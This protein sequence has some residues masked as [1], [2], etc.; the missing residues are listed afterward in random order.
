MSTRIR[1]FDFETTG[2]K[3]FNKTGKAEVRYA[4]LGSKLDYSKSVEQL[5]KTMRFKEFFTLRD[6]LTAVCK[7]ENKTIMY[8]V[9][10]SKFDGE[11]VVKF[12]REHHDL[13]DTL[14]EADFK[15]DKEN[16]NFVKSP[17]QLTDYEIG[18]KAFAITMD[19][20][21]KI[22]EIRLR[23]I[24]NK[25]IIFRCFLNL[26]GPTMGVKACMKALKWDEELKTI[27]TQE[28]YDLY[29]CSHDEFME[30][31]KDI[32]FLNKRREY[33]RYDIVAPTAYILNDVLNN[34]YSPFTVHQKVPLTIASHSFSLFKKLYNANNSWAYASHFIGYKYCEEKGCESRWCKHKK[35]R[36]EP[37]LS[38]ELYNDIMLF[39]Y[40][41]GYAFYNEKYLDKVINRVASM[42]IHSSYPYEYCNK[43]LPYGKPRF[44]K[45]KQIYTNKDKKLYMFFIEI[46][47]LRYKD[48][49]NILPPFFPASRVSAN[50]RYIINYT[51][52]A[53]CPKIKIGVWKE[54]LDDF[55]R[56]YE[57]E[58]TYSYT[59]EFDCDNSIGEVMKPIVA[60]KWDKTITSEQRGGAKLIANSFTGKFGENFEKTSVV[61]MIDRN[62][63]VQEWAKN[64]IFPKKYPP[65][66]SRI[67]YLARHHL[68]MQE[69]KVLKLG[70][71]ILYG[72]TDSIKF[73]NIKITPE[74]KKELNIGDELGQWGLEWENYDFK[75]LAPK[76][77]IFR[78]GRKWQSKMKGYNKPIKFKNFKYGYTFKDKLQR[79][80][81]D[82]GVYL[83]NGLYTISKSANNINYPQDWNKN[84][85]YQE[86]IWNKFKS[87]YL[88]FET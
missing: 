2:V 72:D 46:T 5:R 55:L 3:Y 37:H 44:T 26:Y 30:K 82:T 78:S 50:G 87:S 40:R 22:Y 49:P 17:K 69:Q 85:K 7:L 20:T 53:M 35:T 10:L 73:S 88:N 42:D 77:Y 25:V 13:L 12:F 84:K 18:D 32:N 14:K 74:V 58:F 1:L 68:Y 45:G 47:K 33:I 27:K 83:K 56:H 75:Y 76:S 8:A 38:N 39:G 80:R 59:L 48:D 70:G 81:V 11:F 62:N 54:E 36:R 79:K 63:E 6:F 61:M 34:S 86:I 71:T 41:G 29:D 31:C 60:L 9:N 24:Y 57:M 21:K 43:K 23:S 4:G 19:D 65:V 52:D 51:A 64:T 67:T 15:K 16:N 66:I 28:D